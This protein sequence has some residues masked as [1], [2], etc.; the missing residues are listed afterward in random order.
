MEVSSHRLNF[1][2]RHAVWTTLRDQSAWHDLTRQLH[3]SETYLDQVLRQLPVILWAV[4]GDNRFTLCVGT[5]LRGLPANLTP[6]VGAR[7]QD[8]LAS[9]PDFP[10]Q[11][12][13]ARKGERF[14]ALRR[15]GE[16]LWLETHYTPMPDEQG[17]PGVIG[18]SFD[19][20]DREQAA[21][22]CSCRRRCSSTRV[23]ALSSPTPTARSLH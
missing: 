8:C 12:E 17:R 15:F 9:L 1:H 16:R 4:D 19:V 11:I 14:S 13:R 10:F 6:V 20:S 2:G 22:H 18:M 7:V 5:G 3:L 21:E 23:K